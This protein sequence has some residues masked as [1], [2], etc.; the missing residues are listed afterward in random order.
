MY[1]VEEIWIARNTLVNVD[2]TLVRNSCKS[3][4]TPLVKLVKS[5]RNRSRRIPPSGCKAGV[6]EGWPRRNV[7][8]RVNPNYEYREAFVRDPARISFDS[9]QEEKAISVFNGVVWD[10]IRSNDPVLVISCQYMA[11]LSKGTVERYSRLGDEVSHK[12]GKSSSLEV[13]SDAFD[14]YLY[15]SADRSASRKHTIRFE[16]SGST[17]WYLAEEARWLPPTVR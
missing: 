8:Y 6:A 1:Q 13:G 5:L 17:S 11:N 7:D 9:T 3:R 4:F 10:G 15:A 14:L 2:N 16:P 12:A